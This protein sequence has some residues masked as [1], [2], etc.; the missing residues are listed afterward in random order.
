MPRAFGGWKVLQN[1]ADRSGAAFPEE[2][3]KSFVAEWH[4]PNLNLTC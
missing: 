1:N 2:I 4:W 3:K